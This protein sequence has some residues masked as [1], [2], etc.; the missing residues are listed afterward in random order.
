MKKVYF[1]NLAFGL[2][3]ICIIGIAKSQ[4]FNPLLA[5]KLQ[6]TFDSI[7][8]LSINAKGF[9]ASVYYPGQGIWRGVWGISDSLHPITNDM[10]FSVGSNTKL[11]TASIIMKLVEDSI[12]KLTDHLGKWVPTV[13]NNIDS[14]I[15]I[16]QMLNH[17]S[18]LAD[19]SLAFFDSAQKHPNHPFTVN[20]IFA[21][22][23][24]KL[25][26]P[27]GG[28]NYSN[29]NYM[30]LGMVAESATGINISKLIRD[31]ILTPINL[32]SIFYSFKEPIIGAIA[33]PWVSGVDDTT[34]R[35]GLNS[36]SGA[37]GAIYSTSS[38]MVKWYNFLFSGQIVNNNSL[39]Q[40]TTFTGV[41]NYGYALMKR[42]VLGRTAWGHGGKTLGYLSEMFYDPSLKA[43]VCGINNSDQSSA[44][45]PTFLL[46]KTLID[47]LPDTAKTISGAKTVCLGQSSVTYSVP[48]I[49]RATSYTWTLPSGVTGSSITN[50][51]TVNFT[52]SAV[53]GN[54]TVCGNNMYGSSASSSIAIIV[55]A[56]PNV[57]VVSS[58][59]SITSLGF[60][61]NWNNVPIATNYYLDI[62]TN[63]SFS[64]LVSGYSNLSVPTNSKL[65][66]GLSAS[67]TYYVRVRAANQTC[68]SSS[69]TIVSTLTLCNPPV[70]KVTSNVN[71]SGFTIN[72]TASTG[73]T[74]YLLDVSTSNSF[75]TFLGAYNSLLVPGTSNAIT[76]LLPNT[77]YYFRLKAVNITGSSDYS[78]V[79]TQ[80]TL[81]NSINI[82]ISAFLEGLY[83][84]NNTMMSA[85]NNAT[86][87][88]SNT[89]ADSVIV[90]FYQ[91]NSPF[92]LV[93][94]AKSILNVNG[95]CNVSLPI[96]YL[97]NS[98]YLAIKHRN[99]IETWSSQPIA[100]SSSQI[101]YSFTNSDSQAFGNNLRNFGNGLYL[102][103]SGDINQDGSID[104]NDYPSLDLSSSNGVLGYDSNDLNGDASVDF[105]DYPIIDMNSSNGI[106]L[107]RP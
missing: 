55:N 74:S 47:N 59:T 105:N 29:T 77:T 4:T 97:G 8:N 46:L 66:T 63:A 35:V 99:S 83:I 64:S 61:I 56:K 58:F 37:A 102:I 19:N 51:I 12:L 41:G 38:D 107:I 10:E 16:T 5:A 95:L 103:Y 7:N 80:T 48:T 53:S 3:M 28:F 9:S 94:N 88:V 34:S 22:Q 78:N 14:S 85:L 79:G 71:L 101:S 11:F 70:L 26:N 82:Q 91:P 13:Y 57:P 87:Q 39:S 73:A 27:G 25:Y 76:G 54:I 81:S 65:V 106:I 72:W 75:S 100:L 90:S 45:A 21:F 18:G 44:A 52:N 17:T 15:S 36:A 2:F 31:S 30:L 24:P 104:F 84:G 20:E 92:S 50:S 32:D 33:H 62:S 49:L 98:Y 60:T 68:I 6:N 89:M 23:A 93:Y 42:V 96:S 67:T 1:R 40:M 69:S 43:S 86:S